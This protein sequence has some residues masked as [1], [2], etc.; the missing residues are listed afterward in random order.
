[1]YSVKILINSLANDWSQ[2]WVFISQSAESCVTEVSVDCKEP[3]Y[4]NTNGFS[5]VMG[6]WNWRHPH[7]T[8]RMQTWS[9]SLTESGRLYLAL[10]EYGSPVDQYRKEFYPYY[11]TDLISEKQKMVLFHWK[12]VSY[13]QRL[14]LSSCRY[15]RR[16]LIRLSHEK[17]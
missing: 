7:S 10:N 14:P 4:I 8:R 5:S 3:M 16:R 11:D 2:S 6:K 12:I 9:P 15:D 17:Y 13:D 1:M